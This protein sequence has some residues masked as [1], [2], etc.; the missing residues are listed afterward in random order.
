MNNRGLNTMTVSVVVPSFRRPDMLSQCLEH[1]FAQTQ[2]PDEIIVCA[3]TGDDETQKMLTSFRRPSVRVAFTS[4]AGVVAAMNA[5]ITISRGNIVALLDD[6]A[7]P[8]ADWLERIVATFRLSAS[9]LGVGGLDLQQ[10]PDQKNLKNRNLAVGTIAWYGRLHGNHHLGIGDARSVH[11]LKGCN[12]A[13]RGEFLRRVGIDRYL[14]GAGA[15]VGWEI[16]LA[17]DAMKTGG[18]LIYDPAIVV[19][20]MTA[21]RLDADNIHRGTYSAA[22]AY[23]IA[24]NYFSILRR[25]APGLLRYRAILA[26]L[27]LGSTSAPGVLRIFDYRIGDLSERLRRLRVSFRAF[28]DSGFLEDANAAEANGGS[29]VGDSPVTHL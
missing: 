17:L 13:Y 20:H 23:D 19:D 27:M 6:D 16:S 29:R 21:P 11:V 10:N 15:Q 26:E 18:E 28:R 1:V 2:L 8:R 22:A 24:W 3:R 4:V 7:F 5:G 25:K 14:R 12:C 9:I